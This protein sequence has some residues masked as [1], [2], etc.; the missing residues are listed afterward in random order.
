MRWIAG[1]CLVVALLGPG[2]GAIAAE[3]AVPVYLEAGNG[4]D[5]TDGAGGEF[6]VDS[7]DDWKVDL[8]RPVAAHVVRA[9]WTRKGLPNQ[10]LPEVRQDLS[11]IWAPSC[12]PG[13]QEAT[14]VRD[15]V[16]PGPPGDVSFSFDQLAYGGTFENATL[17]VN[18]Q[19]AFTLPKA[20][21][22]VE[23]DKAHAHLFKFGANRLEVHVVK[24]PNA[25][26]RTGACNTGPAVAD[27]GV[28]FLVKG[29]FLADVAV[30]TDVPATEARKASTLQG[31]DGVVEIFNR[32]PSGVYSG[33]FRL[34]INATVKE[35]LFREGPTV[36]GRGVTDCKSTVPA[37]SF[38]PT[39]FVEIT[40]RLRNM[41]PG[42]KA[43]VAFRLVLELDPQ[44]TYSTIRYAREVF[45]SA[46]DPT[47]NN[48]LSNTILFC[49]EGVANPDC[50]NAK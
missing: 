12:T 15:V 49:V 3:P 24:R 42:T 33:R 31:V 20:S 13:R 6:A 14:F 28:R 23:H 7:N 34:L 16:L 2:P 40:C 35:L 4:P 46:D 21:G 38:A 18:G 22:R 11:Y 5:R 9:G 50:A 44:S 19:L 39:K 37:G 27:A 8:D 17:T 1:A 48:T 45:A 26:G 10:T 47:N 36:S 29:S 32:G 30:R 41:P 43:T 25:P